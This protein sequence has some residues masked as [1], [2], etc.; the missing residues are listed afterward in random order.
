MTKGVVLLYQNAYQYIIQHNLNT[1]TMAHSLPVVSLLLCLLLRG[2]LP[3]SCHMSSL[4]MLEWCGTASSMQ[5][6]PPWVCLHARSVMASTMKK[7]HRGCLFMLECCG[8]GL[9]IIVVTHKEGGKA[10]SAKRHTR[11]A[12]VSSCLNPVI[13]SISI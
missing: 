6:H 2:V 13:I 10:A 9:G 7:T 12:R 4:S 1:N 5:R 8:P 3:S 11:W